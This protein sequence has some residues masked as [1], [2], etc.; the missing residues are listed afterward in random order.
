MAGKCEHYNGG[1][2][3]KSCI[4]L[5]TWGKLN[6]VNRTDGC[7]CAN[8]LW[9]GVLLVHWG[10]DPHLVLLVSAS[11]LVLEEGRL[12]S[13]KRGERGWAK[14]RRV[15]EL[16]ET[17]RPMCLDLKPIHWLKGGTVVLTLSPT[18][19]W[20][21]NFYKT[22]CSAKTEHKWKSCIQRGK[23]KNIRAVLFP[24]VRLWIY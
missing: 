9:L 4:R 21:A 12:G 18:V 6:T 15:R 24:L 1:G 19:C 10:P 16:E 23:G 11:R 2:W 22:V 5:K 3:S 17:R 8:V 14:K 13:E 20:E 7:W